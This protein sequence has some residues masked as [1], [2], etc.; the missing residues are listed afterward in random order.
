MGQT[1]II[2]SSSTN[3]INTHLLTVS[4]NLSINLEVSS[5]DLYIVEHETRES[6]GIDKTKALIAW[7]KDRPYNGDH[8]LAI[9]K[10]AD[11]LTEEAQNSILKLL[12]ESNQSVN[13]ILITDNYRNLLQ[14]IQSRCHIISDDSNIK[15][16]YSKELIDKNTTDQLLY[17]RSLIN[18]KKTEKHT[19]YEI[20]EDLLVYY[21]ELLLKDVNIDKVQSNIK[22]VQTTAKMLRANVSPKLALENLIINLNNDID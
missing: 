3:F 12:E 4:R 22:L 14:T 16:E 19:Y 8:K 10:K 1:L 20:L 13:I 15:K 2:S 18:S 21:R 17:I 11:K 6:I 5:P 9:I 7:S